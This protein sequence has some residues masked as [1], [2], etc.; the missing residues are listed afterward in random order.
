MALVFLYLAFVL[1]LGLSRNL[2]RS[3]NLFNSVGL[4]GISA[5]LLWQ[6]VA[7]VIN[8][9]PVVAIVPAAVGVAAAAANWGVARLLRGPSTSNPAIRLAYLHNL[10][11]AQ[12]SLAPVLSGVLVTL[13]GYSVFDPLVA[14]AIALWLIVSTVRETIG[15][16]EE[17][18]TPEKIGCGHTDDDELQELAETDS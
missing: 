16:H 18:I 15:L 17:L 14:A 12:V 2:I 8:P 11:D 1:P 7:R 9:L 3:A 5:V 6:A 13:T 10:G 4:A